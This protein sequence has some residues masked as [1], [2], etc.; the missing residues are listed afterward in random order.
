M[1]PGR[2]LAAWRVE[3]PAA[4]RKSMRWATASA[5]PCSLTLAYMAAK[6]DRR[7]VTGTFLTSLVDFTQAGEM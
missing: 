2:A 4:K 6:K 5:A 3:K 1:S 7:I